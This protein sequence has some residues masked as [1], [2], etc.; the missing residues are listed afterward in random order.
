[1]KLHFILFCVLS[2][3]FL[4]AQAQTNIQA[5]YKKGQVWIVWNETLTR[6]DIYEVYSSPVAFTTT[7]QA[8]LVGKLAHWEWAAGAIKDQ[9][10]DPAF[11]WKVPHPTQNRRYQLD[12]LQGLFVY[13][14][15]AED[16]AYFAVVKRGDSLVTPGVNGTAAAVHYYIDP[17]TCHKQAGKILPG[18]HKATL[19]AMWADGRE[20]HWN[21]RPDFP[22]MAN[23]HK[24]GQPGIF[25]VSE[26][27]GMDTTG[28]K[29]IPATLWLHGG[30]GNAIQSLPTGR[31]FV[32]IEPI[33]GILVAHND[34]LIGY[35]DGVLNEQHS[36]SWFFGWAKNKDP[37]DLVN[38]AVTENDTIINYTQRRLDWV[39][40]WLIA[41]YQV[42]SERIYLNGHSMGAA[43]ATALMKTYPN[44][45]A[46]VSIF[47]NGLGGHSNTS[48][49]YSLFGDIIW[50]NPT[51]LYR[52]DGS[53]VAIKQA[54]NLNDRNSPERDLPLVRMFHGKTDDNGVMMWDAYVVSEYKKADS[55]G[56]GM[57]LYWSERS[58]GIETGANPNHPDHWTHGEEDTTQTVRDN[59]AYGETKYRST[60]FPAFYNHQF[61]PQAP[62]PGDGS[63]GLTGSGG[64]GDDWGT[65]GGYHDWHTDSLT[66]EPD[67][68]QVCAWL[69]DSAVY[70]N[71]NS[72]FDSLISSLAIRKPHQFK[73]LT[74]T[75]VYWSEID[76][77]TNVVIKSGATTVGP[78]D[79]VA[80]DSVVVF[81]YP[82]KTYITFALVPAIHVGSLLPEHTDDFSI[83]PNPSGDQ[84]HIRAQH[85]VA[86]GK[87]VTLYN[88]AGAPLM[89]FRAGENITTVDIASLKPDTY[90][91]KFNNKTLR[92]IKK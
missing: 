83:F 66:D 24:N 65:W 77:A 87:W 31:T 72:P 3:F 71:D 50:N 82:V 61:E 58:H 59:T 33:K 13:T 69:M 25:M 27:I 91:V 11:N 56:W 17:V 14:P 15:P 29:K 60:S 85:S 2:Y 28:G 68:W 10:N 20:D 35:N 30:G 1:M 4:E 74:G 21:G 89:N 41:N 51:N 63:I 84:L 18:G 45:Y 86:A 39:N 88:A 64:T 52:R 26:A 62:D 54:F 49:G 55:L 67:Q 5:W 9:L 22:V 42:D 36:N 90:F 37:Y 16:S 92:F 47:N 79:L 44:R 19:W 12:S 48:Q 6:P 73:P 76:S 7:R 46:T 70:D 78:D 8:T 53:N 40:D 34:D 38:N 81:R 32:N 57:Q 75:T 43:G 23:Q 80:I